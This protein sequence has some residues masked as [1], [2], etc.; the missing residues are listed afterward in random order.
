MED[1]NKNDVRK[2]KKIVVFVAILVIVVAVIA[3][4]IILSNRGDDESNQNNSN[5]SKSNTNITNSAVKVGDKFTRNLDGRLVDKKENVNPWLVGVMIENLYTVRPQSGLSAAPLVYETL[6]EGGITR[7]IA[8]FIGDEN[9]SQIGPVRS[10]RPYYIEW[11]SEFDAL[12][13]HCGGSPTALAAISGLGIKDLNQMYSPY[14]YWRANGAE[15]PHNLFT[16]SE[17]LN[18]ALRDKE[19]LDKSFEYRV[20]QYKDDGKLSS[21]PEG[22]KTIEIDFS[23]GSAY[24]V[25][26]KYDKSSN[27]YLRYQMGAVQKDAANKAEIRAKNVVV[28]KVPA[29]DYEADKGRLVLD[30]SGEGEAWVFRD[31]VGIHGKWQKNDRTTRT[32]FLDDNGKEIEFNRGITWI[33]VVPG[34]RA[35]NYLEE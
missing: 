23:A 21:L 32:I 18:R 19:L 26:W 9:L 5:S 29:E 33:E 10:A 30:V 6:A 34:D 14:Y 1:K 16:S 20:W 35:V 27:D 31:G 13:S 12:Y 4:I 8:F 25:E 15:A 3:V 28:E 2:K 17:L 24:D 11:L 7:F 22:S